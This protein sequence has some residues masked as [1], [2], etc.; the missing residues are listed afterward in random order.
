M[1]ILVTGA[2][3][4][5]AQCLKRIVDLNFNGKPGH[6]VGEKNY[7][8]FKTKEELPIGDLEAV[9]KVVKE[10]FINVIVNCAAYT[11]VNKAQVEG[12]E[13][14]ELVNVVG[15]K[16][17]AKVA[18]EVGAV[19][20]HISTDYVFSALNKANTPL[21]PVDFNEDGHLEHKPD[22]LHVELEDNAYGYTKLWGE[23]VILD[24]G[25]RYII[26]R[27]SWLYSW[28]G[29]NFVKTMYNKLM[30]QEEIKVVYDQV[31]SP[32]SAHELAMFIYHIIENH[33]PETR[34]L[35]KEGIYN[36]V[37]NGVA[38]WYDI[39][40]QILQHL[41]TVHEC[42]LHYAR[43]SPCLS[44]EFPQPVK[45]PNYSVLDNSLTQST[46]DYKI[47]YWAESLYHVVDKLFYDDVST[48]DKNEKIE[49]MLNDAQ[50]ALEKEISEYKNMYQK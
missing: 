26:I 48:T 3:G 41:I 15:T 13:L 30:N 17:L 2:N 10:E 33:G 28:F 25:C 20:I 14:A 39:V 31:G 46:F 22:Y 42:D 7:Y 50:K 47:H 29:K 4:Q 34:Y 24:S 21:P 43:V 45:R 40:E 27:T 37:E 36:F 9:R 16:N 49:E 6:Y 44:S 12:K 18:A 1:N 38:S 35:C 8:I 19:L 23:K 11:D 5:L 32:T